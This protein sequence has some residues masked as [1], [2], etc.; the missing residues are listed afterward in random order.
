MMSAQTE[1]DFDREKIKALMEEATLSLLGQP[2]KIHL[3]APIR[4]GSRGGAYKETDGFAMSL[5]PTLDLE[6]FYLCWLHEVAH[7]WLGHADDLEPIDYSELPPKLLE[8]IKQGHFLPD[9][10]EGE[11]KAYRDSQEEK[12]ADAFA[13]D[14]DHIARGKAFDELHTFNVPV[15][16]RIRVLM[17][18]QLLR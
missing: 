15:E 10:T 5:L 18:T 11:R 12:D 9:M 4:E 14:M 3:R 17:N 13:L 16:T 6:D 2:V 8:L 1:S 7:I